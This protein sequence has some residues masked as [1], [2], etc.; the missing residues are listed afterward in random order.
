MTGAFI[1]TNESH[2]HANEKIKVTFNV[3]GRVRQVNAAVIWTR[4]NGVGVRFQP[5]NN[6]DTQIV[7]DLIYFIE[8][9]RNSRRSVLDTIFEV[10]T[11]EKREN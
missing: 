2:L 11:N 3:R 7:D 8:S 6:Q 10:V 4:I 1:E 5:F 9:Q